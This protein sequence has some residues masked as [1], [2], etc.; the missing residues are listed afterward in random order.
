MARRP[1]R[2]REAGVSVAVANRQRLVRVAVPWLT[3]L[4]R[5]G[6]AAEGVDQAEISIV[7]VDDRRI[8]RL[9]D[10]WFDDGAPHG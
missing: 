2:I 6:L 3:R 5:R 10:E 7:L 9:H 4:V 1:G 8:G